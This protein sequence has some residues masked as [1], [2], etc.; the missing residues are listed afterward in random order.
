VVFAEGDAADANADEFV[1]TPNTQS[2]AA[3]NLNDAPLDVTADEVAA[4][5]VDLA[6]VDAASVDDL[7]DFD[8]SHYFG[9]HSG[10]SHWGDL[11]S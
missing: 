9:H 11:A 1:F 4:A 7:P 6:P 3:A 5:P 2:V 8:V 10:W